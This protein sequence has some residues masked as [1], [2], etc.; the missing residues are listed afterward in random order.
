MRKLTKNQRNE[1]KNSKAAKATALLALAADKEQ[2]SGSCLTVPEMAELVDGKGDSRVIEKYRHHLSGCEH[3]YEQWL[4][5]HREQNRRASGAKIHYLSR[6]RKYRYIGSALAVAASVAVFINIYYIQ[7]GFDE[8]ILQESVQLE[9]SAELSESASPEVVQE[10]EQSPGGLL[11]NQVS[12]GAPVQEFDRETLMETKRIAPDDE[13]RMKKQQVSPAATLPATSRE[14]KSL[15][16]EVAESSL[17]SPADQVNVDAWSRQLM[18]KCQAGTVDRDYWVA[19]HALGQKLLLGKPETLGKEKQ[20]KVAAVISI[21]GTM[22]PDLQED[23]CRQ[24]IA[25]L[26]EGRWSR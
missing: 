11:Q 19:M 21:L 17:Q 12:D 25:I 8:Q 2:Q 23:Q 1:E 24:I 5:L 7:L 26:A 20:K 14:E 10:S 3:C 15:P 22:S 13:V 9:K 18:E 4:S 16:M 6:N